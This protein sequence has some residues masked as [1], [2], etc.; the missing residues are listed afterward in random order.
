MILANGQTH[1]SMEQKKKYRYKPIQI[2]Q[3]IFYKL[4]KA[5]QQENDGLFKKLCLNN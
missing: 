1:K 5:I 2:C 3:L 4:A